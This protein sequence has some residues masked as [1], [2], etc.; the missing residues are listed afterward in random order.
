MAYSKPPKGG[1]YSSIAQMVT[2]KELLA[3]SEYIRN[4]KEKYYSKKSVIKKKK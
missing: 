2:I 4:F 1:E 3:M